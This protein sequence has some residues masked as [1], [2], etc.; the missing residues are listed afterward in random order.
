MQ[1]EDAVGQATGVPGPPPSLQQG[2]PLAGGF[3]GHD[4]I[5]IERTVVVGGK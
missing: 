5:S 1:E 3:N 2:V 4:I